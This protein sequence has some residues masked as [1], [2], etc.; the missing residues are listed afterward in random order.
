M[1]IF[2][3]KLQVAHKETLAA[4]RALGTAKQTFDEVSK[5]I[6][7]IVVGDDKGC[8]VEDND[9]D[10]ALRTSGGSRQVSIVS[11]ETPFWPT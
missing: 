6:L 8:S 11:V 1:S 10:E 4:K 3:N 5:E 2:C 7:V 9:D